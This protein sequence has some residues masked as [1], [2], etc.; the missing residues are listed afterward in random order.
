MALKV[1]EILRA[2]GARMSPMAEPFDVVVLAHDERHVRRKVLTLSGGEKVSIDLP[3]AVALGHGDVLVLE[4]GRMAGI[5]AAD[6][7]LYEI[8][9]HD[10]PHLA[11]IAWHLGNR[12][13]QAAI[14]EARILIV[15][16]HVIKTMLEG[17][18]ATVTEVTGRFEPMRGAYSGHGHRKSSADAGHHND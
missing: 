15:R 14:E 5:V 6:E 3:Q 18:G 9:A 7:D 11:E 17:L 13:L 1:E 8:R 12:H 16:D 10:P 2:A 4:D